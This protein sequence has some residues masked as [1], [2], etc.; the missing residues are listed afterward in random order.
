MIEDKFIN[1]KINTSADASIKG[2]KLQKLRVIKYLL[3][4]VIS[5]KKMVFSTIEHIDDVV[6]MEIDGD[7]FD[8]TTEQDKNYSTSF[9]I[10]N[11]EIKNSLRIFFD[12][13]RKV[14]YDENITF[15]FYTTTKVCRER[16]VGVLKNSGVELPKG[17]VLNL[18]IEKKYDDAFPIVLPIFKDYYI[19]QHKKHD[20]QN[21]YYEKLME[22]MDDEKWKVFFDL[23]EW[24]F[25][26][27]NEVELVETL[28]NNIRKVC[29]IF[30]VDKKYTED[31]YLKIVGLVESKSGNTEFLGKMV[32]VAEI[33]L[34]FTKLQR[35]IK[36]EKISNEENEELDPMYEKWDVIESDDIRNLEK[37]ILD[38]CS[39]FDEDE[40]EDLQ[41]LLIEGEFEQKKYPDIRKV[42]AYNYRIYKECRRYIKKTLKIRESYEFTQLE[43][44][45]IMNDMVNLSYEMILDK[46]KTYKIPYKDEDMVKKTI[47]ILFEQCFLALDKVGESNG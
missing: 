7:K 19:N 39:D 26:E 5:G 8:I 34:I 4:A 33:E 27:A 41:E 24:K 47:L 43:I 17:E 9:S 31:I 40:I 16:K 3:E 32:H 11:E 29:D 35:E 44:D 46:N 13:W 10:N 6:K 38:V 37:K 14:E 30:N 1:N 25:E 28:K 21:T 36:I 15:V 2:I 20:P 42:K 12:N 45:S 23:I 18:L 22:T